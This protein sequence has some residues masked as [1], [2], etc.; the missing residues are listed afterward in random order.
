MLEQSVLLLPVK[1]P[2]NAGFGHLLSCTIPCATQLSCI[3]VV[4]SPEECSGMK[5]T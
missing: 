5:M 2:Y 4:W 1:C 3:C